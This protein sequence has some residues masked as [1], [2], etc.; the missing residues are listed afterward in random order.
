MNKKKKKKTKE[1]T[2]IMMNRIEKKNGIYT[3]TTIDGQTF[4]CDRW[5]EKKVDKWHV[6][7][8][9]EAREICGRTYIRESHFDDKNVYEFETKT[10]HRE[11]L[12]NGGWKARLTKEELEE[13]EAH[14]KR[15]AE[16]K[17]LAMSR[18]IPELT[19][20]EKLQREIEKMMKKLEALKSSK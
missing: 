12:G 9:V 17:D 3:L 20:E 4:T 14:E 10:E 8:P 18:P 19:E 15:M 7:I 6:R 1:R 5:Y 2:R 13:Y 11:G 16:L